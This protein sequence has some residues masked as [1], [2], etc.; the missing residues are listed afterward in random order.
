MGKDAITSIVA[1][2]TAIIG[3]AI[4]AVLVKAPGTVGTIASAGNAFTCVLGT[5]LSPLGTSSSGCGGSSGFGLTPLVNS[6]ITFGD[7]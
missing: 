7:Q 5:A 6:T 4:V 2:L 3:V 1:I